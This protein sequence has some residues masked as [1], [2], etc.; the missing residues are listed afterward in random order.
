MEFLVR[1]EQSGFSVWVRESRSLFA[2]PGILLLHT[3]G[4]ALLVGIV[5]AIDLR[6]L[7]FAPAL[8]LSAMAKFLPILWVAFWVNAATGTILLIADASS[9]VTN[10]DFLAKMGFIALAVV[11]QRRIQTRIFGDPHLD[12]QPFS[13]NAK[14]LAA[15]SLALWLGAITTGRL[16][17][18]VGSA[19]AKG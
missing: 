11:N 5:A 7:G 19:G 15:T 13:G 1:L 4:M 12:T 3:Y 9:K 16:L 14:M 10:P 6:I 8:P 2:Y 18:Y 17:A